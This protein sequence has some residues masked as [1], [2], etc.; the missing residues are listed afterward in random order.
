MIKFIE[1]FVEFI[2]WLQLFVFP[3]IFSTVLGVV[4]YFYNPFGYGL[5]FLILC[6]ALGLGIGIWYANRV[7]RKEGAVNHLSTL[8]R[9]PELERDVN[10]AGIGKN[11]K[12][13]KNLK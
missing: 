7:H 10:D 6:V 11:I 12:S 13:E 9:M 5:V 1:K 2:G 3:L 4:L 8:L